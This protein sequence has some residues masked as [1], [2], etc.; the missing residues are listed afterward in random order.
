MRRGS[1]AD[2]L[3]ELRIRISV[4]YEVVELRELHIAI[5]YL[6]LYYVLLWGKYSFGSKVKIKKKKNNLA[7]A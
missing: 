2:C 3:M 5:M 4:L 1:A 6:V 7:A